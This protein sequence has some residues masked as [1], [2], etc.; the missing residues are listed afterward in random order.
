MSCM[1]VRHPVAPSLFGFVVWQKKKDTKREMKKLSPENCKKRREL[2][3]KSKKRREDEK[4]DEFESWFYM[5]DDSN[6]ASSEYDN[7]S[8]YSE[9]PTHTLWLNY[10]YVTAEICIRYSWL[11]P[12]IYVTAKLCIIY[13]WVMQTLRLS[14]NQIMVELCICYGWV[15]VTL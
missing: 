10:A 4:D 14:Y 11:I 3:K 7:F 2:N 1:V 6:G 15:M 8:S 9:S 5:F 13:D 12:F